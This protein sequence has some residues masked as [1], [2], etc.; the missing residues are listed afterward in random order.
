MDFPEPV[1]FP[2]NNKLEGAITFLSS[3]DATHSNEFSK[4]DKKMIGEICQ[5]ICFVNFENIFEYLKCKNLPLFASFQ[6][7]DN[8]GYPSLVVQFGRSKY[9]ISIPSLHFISDVNRVINNALKTSITTLRECDVCHE[10]LNHSIYKGICTENFQRYTE[11]DCF[12]C[13][14]NC[15]CVLCYKCS[16]QINICPLCR[17]D[18][19]DEHCKLFKSLKN[20]KKLKMQ[21]SIQNR[22]FKQKY[23][24][25][26]TAVHYDIEFI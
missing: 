4:K 20:D 21:L 7:G 24:H 6:S 13:C 12:A 26:C 11:I 23:Q 8:A 10:I 25:V 9:I 19:F 15:N 22:I 2:K 3:C 1:R 14:I 17:V 5:H 18:L 16:M